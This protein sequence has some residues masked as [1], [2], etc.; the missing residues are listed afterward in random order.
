MDSNDLAFV[1][2]KYPITGGAF[3]YSVEL[4]GENF[5]LFSAQATL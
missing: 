1:W 3:T 2:I 4:I 5:R